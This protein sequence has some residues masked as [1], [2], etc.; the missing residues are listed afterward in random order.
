MSKQNY[1][2]NQ[3]RAGKYQEGINARHH[4]AKVSLDTDLLEFLK[5][6]GWEWCPAYDAVYKREQEAPPARKARRTRICT[7]LHMAY[8]HGSGR[9]KTLRNLK[10]SVE[11]LGCW[12]G[13]RGAGTAGVTE[14]YGLLQKHGIKPFKASSYPRVALDKLL[15]DI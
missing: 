11:Q 13:F 5:I 6:A 4:S 3:Y 12:L 7:V 15:G 10:E 9:I 14:F 8:S 2:T 1:N